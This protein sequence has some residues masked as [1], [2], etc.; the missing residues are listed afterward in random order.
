MKE[1]TQK[2]L[3][4]EDETLIDVVVGAFIA[5]QLSTDPVWLLVIAPPSTAKTEILTA[6]GRSEGAL[7]ISGFTRATLVSGLP[8]KKGM[9][10]PSLVTRINGKTLVVKE[11]SS[12]LSMYSE[13]QAQVLTQLREIYD[14][15]LYR[16]FGNGKEVLF[17]GKAGLIGACTPAWDR[18]HA[19]VGSLG[20]RFILYRHHSPDPEAAGLK[21]L[22]EQFGHE[23]IMREELA[24]IYSEFLGQFRPMPDFQF[25]NNDQV[26]FKI[27]QLATF[28]AHGRCTVE[29]DRYTQ[30]ISYIPESEG[31]P[32]MAKQLKSLGV[33][34]ALAHGKNEIDDAVYSI[35]KRVGMDLIE[36][37]RTILLKYL[38]SE[39]L[40]EFVGWGTTRDIADACEL[41]AT[42]AKYILE[43]LQLAGLLNR[44]LKPSS[45][46]D[47]EDEAGTGRKPYEW[48]IKQKA[49]NWIKASDVM[50]DSKGK[51]PF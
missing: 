7:L 35:I 34:V 48:Q 38:W 16:S 49:E 17:E 8:K 6:V 28:C 12:V 37:R 45:G 19:V 27:S 3:I 41:P 33:G 18:H 30:A 36:S 9:K 42:S 22:K 20:D 50:D 24:N 4:L 26:D 5:N 14:G 51:V 44:R 23:K 29:R 15:H 40:T 39:N 43:D 21:S 25:I 31:P 10:E 32:R 13:E 47:E 11:F 46:K 2:W 1:I